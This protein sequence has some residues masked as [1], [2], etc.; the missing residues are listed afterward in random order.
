MTAMVPSP[1]A[2]AIEVEQLERDVAVEGTVPGGPCLAHASLAE[3][4]DQLDAESQS[5][6][7]TGG[8]Q[9]DQF[10]GLLRS[11]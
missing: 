8:L 7:W 10:E 3:S 1:T 9:R 11:F 2:E 5:M 4:L 6:G